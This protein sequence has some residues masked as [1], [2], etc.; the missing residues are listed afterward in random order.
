MW[1]WWAAAYPHANGSGDGPDDR[2]TNRREPS[3]R[4]H[5][6]E[7]VA[8]GAPACAVSRHP[9][10]KEESVRDLMLQERMCPA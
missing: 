3:S 2:W 4:T 9:H 8:I 10:T 7:V 1:C 6:R 5:S